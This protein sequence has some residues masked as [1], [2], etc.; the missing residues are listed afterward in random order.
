M[1]CKEVEL[2]LEQ[3]GIV[4]LPGAVRAHLASCNTCQGLVADLGDIVAA[5]REL[6]A[7]LEPPARAWISLRAQLENEGIIKTSSTAG[8]GD[9][10]WWQGIAEL[11][12]G[13]ALATAAVGL[14]IVAAGILQIQRPAV[15]V[16]DTH[17]PFEETARALTEQEHGLANMQLAS[18]SIVDTSLRQNLTAVDD[19]IADCER[20]VQA[21]PRDDLARE[22]LSGAYRQKAQLL[23]AMMERGGS[24]N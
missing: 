4:P 12:R 7:E 10:S 14:L 16:V 6:P 8:A 13:R 24:G 1:Q 3:E 20:R 17:N 2:V 22:Y 9:V 15:E 18:N 11:L 19:F 5:A 21:E 23:S